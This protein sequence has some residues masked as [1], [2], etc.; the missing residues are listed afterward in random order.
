[1][2]SEEIKDTIFVG[3]I[4]YDM[5]LED[6]EEEISTW[7]NVTKKYL[8]YHGGWGTVSFDSNSSRNRFLKDKSKHKLWN[9]LVD[10]KPY[11]YNPDKV[12]NSGPGHLV[13]GKGQVKMTTETSLKAK[14]EET[15]SNEA[16]NMSIIEKQMSDLQ[17]RYNL[18]FST[19][20]EKKITNGKL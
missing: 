8:K 3:G 17:V 16:K 11:I 13:I 10:V 20:L 2:N 7:G 1:M 14:A 15:K 18:I 4:P 19:F 6:F 5:T 9:K 12:K